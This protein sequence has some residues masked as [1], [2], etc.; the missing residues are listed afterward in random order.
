MASE[1]FAKKYGINQYF[2]LPHVVQVD[3]K[4][5]NSLWDQK[6]CKKQPQRL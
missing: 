1:Q 6:G 2:T 3:S 5:T 4:W